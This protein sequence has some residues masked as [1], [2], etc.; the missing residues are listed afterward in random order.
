MVNAFT[1]AVFDYT[2][3]FEGIAAQN[4][5]LRPLRKLLCPPFYLLHIDLLAN[6]CTE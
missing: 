1:D 6:E 4:Y 5:D 3:L 2:K